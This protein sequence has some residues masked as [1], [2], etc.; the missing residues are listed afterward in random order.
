MIFNN[1]TQDDI[2]T[3]RGS[4]K[5]DSPIKYIMFIKEVGESGTPYF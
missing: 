1:Y 4:I 3:F 2:D 5:S